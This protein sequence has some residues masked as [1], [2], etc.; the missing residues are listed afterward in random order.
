[1]SLLRAIHE[2]HV[3]YFGTDKQ[4]VLQRRA[5]ELHGWLYSTP[6]CCHAGRFCATDD[7]HLL[8][9][10]TIEEALRR[11]EVFGFRLRPAAQREAISRH[12]Q[13]LGY[14]LHTWN[15]FHS[16]ANNLLAPAH[17]F[18]N[19]PL[20]SDLTEHTLEPGDADT[21]VLEIQK[22]LSSNGIAPFSARLLRSELGQ[23][24]TPY[25]RDSSGQVIACAH[26]YLPHNR[27]SPYEKTA[28]VGLVAV[29]AQQR[30]RRLG[31]RINA[32]SICLAIEALGANAVY[33]LVAP[34][35]DASRRMVE[36]CGL[37]LRPDL[38][39]GIAMAG[40]QRFTK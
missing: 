1:M 13:T 17:G 9:W 10:D 7:E 29:A 5:D 33:E 25:I 30:G 40:E 21:C 12:V 34:D 18:A 14:Q 20:P 23:A 24:A 37:A 11:D 32:R 36:S 26:A 3:T 16:D 39:C 4:V 27:Y 28:W 8:G 2:A 35:N 22:F 19:E 6:G 31:T 38:M 15:V